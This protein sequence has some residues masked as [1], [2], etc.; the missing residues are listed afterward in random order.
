M[1]FF[2]MYL[3]CVL[4]QT[5]V[6]GGVYFFVKCTLPTEALE[7]HL[8]YKNYLSQY[9]WQGFLPVDDTVHSYVLPRYSK[10]RCRYPLPIVHSYSGSQV[11]VM[12]WLLPIVRYLTIT[13]QIPKSV[14]FRTRIR[15]HHLPQGTFWIERHTCSIRSS[16]NTFLHFFAEIFLWFIK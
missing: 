2:W 14:R 1:Y 3:Y 16:W 9:Y 11:I 4:F 10:V 5:Q 6:S 15:D 7:I 13:C 12:E 8:L